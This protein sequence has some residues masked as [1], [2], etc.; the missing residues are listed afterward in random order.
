[1]LAIILSLLII[2]GCE[3]EKNIM[4]SYE[5]LTDKENA[6]ANVM[7][8]NI[9]RYNI[10]NLPIDKN[11]KIQGFYE[12]Y[13]NGEKIKEDLFLDTFSDSDSPKIENMSLPLNYL[14]DEIKY[15]MDMDG[16]IANGGYDMDKNEDFNSPGFFSSDLTVDIEIEFN[17]DI[18]IHE[19]IIANPKEN[20]TVYESRAGSTLGNVNKKEIENAVK[21]TK[22][23]TFVKLRISE[24]K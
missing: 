18:Y 1:M 23:A 6:I 24:V 14:E 10:K 19:N 7:G 17:R 8:G 12:A 15:A 3:K 21:N 16:V 22:R 2:S 9:R 4:L 20:G 5:K 13:E 11:Y